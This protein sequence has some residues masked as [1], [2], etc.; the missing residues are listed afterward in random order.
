MKLSKVILLLLFATFILS[1]IGFYNG[2]PLVYSDTGTYIYCGFNLFIP[3]DRPIP[4]GLFIRFFSLRFSLWL[5]VFVQNFLTAFVIYEV[6]R[7]IKIKKNRIAVI[8]LS[9][10][11]FLVMV[12]GIGWYSNQIM[13][14][15]FAPLVIMSIYILLHKRKI[16]DFSGIFIALLLIFSLVVHFT[17]MMIGTVLLLVLVI[18]RFSRNKYFG[19]ITLQRIGII[20]VLVLSSWIILPGVNYLIER[21]F[22]F[23]KGS[24]V[25]LMAHLVDTGILEK[26]LNENCTDKEYKDC[27]L[28]Q[29]KDVLPG[30]LSQFLWEDSIL[31]KTG[32]W[33]E[34]EKEYNKIIFGTLKQPKYLF[35]NIWKSGTYGLVEL[36]QNH[37]GAGLS[38]YRKGSAPWGQISWRFHTELNSYL[39]ARQ[40]IFNGMNMNLDHINVIQS[41]LLVLSLLL[42]IYFF[43]TPILKTLDPGSVSFLF[44]TILGIVVNAF[45]T[46]GLNS[47][48]SRFEARVVWLLPFALIIIL[49]KNY[50]VILKKVYMRH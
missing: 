26:F 25:F 48:T 19:A 43:T 44:L 17:H 39:N 18:F 4:Y 7:T 47:P 30:D 40:N 33:N 24:H 50:K 12:T 13:P 5:V 45:V 35:L 29:Y 3:K 22:I 21:K 27:K 34:S 49:V 46:G 6:L 36:T 9:I 41:Y 14:D 32:G 10:I 11:T 16:M 23:S 1:I 2:Y 15:F 31:T 8:Y 28:C 42:L 20:S 38:P 37:I